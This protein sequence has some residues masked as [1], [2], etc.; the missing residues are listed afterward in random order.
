MTNGVRIEPAHQG[1]LVVAVHASFIDTDM[2]AR[3]DAPKI[4]SEVV[5]RQAMDAAESGAIEV[6]ADERTRFVKPSLSR[7]HEL[8]YPAIQGFWDSITQAPKS[9]GPAS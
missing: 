8:V 7:D 5:P 3:I 6:L 1:T 2:A 9:A 4:G